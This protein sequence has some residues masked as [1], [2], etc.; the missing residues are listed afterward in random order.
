[1]GEIRK[2][3]ILSDYGTADYYKY[4]K[5]KGGS[6]NYSTYTKI[7]RRFNILVGELIV[8]NEYN[9]KLP[10]RLGILSVRKIK[11]YVKFVD[12]KVKT[13]LPIN[14][15]ETNELWAVDPV[16]KAERRRVYIENKHSNGYKYKFTYDKLYA[17]YTN[18]TVYFMQF[19]RQLKRKL[20]EY[21]QAQGEIERGLA[22]Y[23]V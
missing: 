11:T 4:Y 8:N 5:D 12:G 10:A 14:H 22:Y 21:I 3:K 15:K 17:N 7:L 1:M 9:Y 18:K 23:V 2:H 16:A 20:K 19:N 6:L 13:N